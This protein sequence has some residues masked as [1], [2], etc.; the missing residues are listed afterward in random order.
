MIK[1]YVIMLGSPYFTRSVERS[2][3]PSF[4]A[5]CKLWFL[6]F[7]NG[8]GEIITI[9]GRA[10]ITAWVNACWFEEGGREERMQ[11]T[12]IILSEAARDV[13]SN[14]CLFRGLR[15]VS[16]HCLLS[17]REGWI[18]PWP[19]A[20]FVRSKELFT[21]KAHDTSNVKS[22][23]VW[24]LLELISPLCAV[25]TSIFLVLKIVGSHRTTSSMIQ[26]CFP[27]SPDCQ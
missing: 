18:P 2:G 24:A 12:K 4:E 26:L 14:N 17:L 8:G 1:L 3:M 7:L 15:L 27:L 22:K 11:V 6:D 13:Y 10:Q 21:F 25:T 16:V 5:F 9:I 20:I 23:T 19:T